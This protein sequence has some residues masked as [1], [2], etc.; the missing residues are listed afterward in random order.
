MAACWKGLV[1]PGTCSCPMGTTKASCCRLRQAHQHTK[2]TKRVATKT[3]IPTM[4]G[5]KICDCESPLDKVSEGCV[6]GVRVEV[7]AVVTVAFTVALEWIISSNIFILLMTCGGIF[8]PFIVIL[9][10]VSSTSPEQG[11]LS[12]PLISV[13]RVFRPPLKR[14]PQNSSL[15]PFE[16]FVPSKQSRF[17]LSKQDA[18][19]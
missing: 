12:K 10:T 7:V 3:E 1:G 14:T 4:M 8:G 16:G 6:V 5:M 2:T 15:M 17:A 11:N 9:W 18:K 19:A 13:S